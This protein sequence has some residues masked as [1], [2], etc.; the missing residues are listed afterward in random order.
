MSS[1]LDNLHPIYEA[2][3]PGFEWGVGWTLLAIFLSAIALSGSYF[4]WRYYRATR[5]RRSALAILKALQKQ[6]DIAATFDLIKRVLLST[7]ERTE[8]APLSGDAL[9][10]MAGLHP[11]LKVINLTLFNTANTLSDAQKAQFF[12]HVKA[13]IASQKGVYD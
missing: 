10:D 11:E 9:I 1:S 12:L 5:Y 8:V 6:D 2:V 3:L 4:F 13:W 7:H